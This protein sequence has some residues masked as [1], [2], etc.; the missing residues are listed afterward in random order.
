M[1]EQEESKRRDKEVSQSHNFY[2]SS[3]FVRASDQF[4]NSAYNFTGVRG[5]PIRPDSRLFSETPIKMKISAEQR[6]QIKLSSPETQVTNPVMTVS[7]QQQAI[8]TKVPI[9]PRESKE[10]FNQISAVSVMKK[11]FETQSTEQLESQPRFNT[12]VFQG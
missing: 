9:T 12:N 11:K 3:Q 7:P 6:Y 4:N 10:T 5:V 1:L 2:E 8:P